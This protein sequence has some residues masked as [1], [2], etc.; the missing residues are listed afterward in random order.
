MYKNN[1]IVECN[2][3]NTEDVYTTTGKSD[4]GRCVTKF[5]ADLGATEHLTKSKL[6]FKTFDELKCGEIRCANKNNSVNLKTKGGGEIEISLENGTNLEI[7]KVIFANA[8]KENVLSLRKFAEMGLAIY[9]DNKIDIFDPV[10]NERFIS[11]VYK[12]PYW[13]VDLEINTNNA[14]DKSRSVIINRQIFAN[15]AEGE[16]PENKYVTR[17]VS[18]ITRYLIQKQSILQTENLRKITVDVES[19]EN[20]DESL[21]GS[22]ENKV[23]SNEMLD[24]NEYDKPKNHMSNQ[25][26]T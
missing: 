9:L 10:S 24:S 1:F 12:R 18:Q 8:L 19:Q 14:T 26:L 5:L 23:S 15:L 22:G 17:S 4:L 13:I 3:L 20:R 11:G 2:L 6:I 7:D 16:L 21:K 25:I